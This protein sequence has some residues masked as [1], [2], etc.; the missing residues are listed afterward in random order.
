LHTLAKFCNPDIHHGRSGRRHQAG[1]IR[2]A[3]HLCLDG[4]HAHDG[5][6]YN[7]N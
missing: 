4:T 6:H 1:E 7:K 3:G 2:Q 5:K